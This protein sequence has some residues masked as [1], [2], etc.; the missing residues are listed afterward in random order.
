MS[1]RGRVKALESKIAPP[2]ERHCYLIVDEAEDGLR[3]PSKCPQGK[4]LD[5]ELS[6]CESCSIRP[7]NRTRL[8][9]RHIPPN[10]RTE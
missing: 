1:S 4:E 9:I 8:I 7:E 5:A 10:A 2:D 6:Q 3:W